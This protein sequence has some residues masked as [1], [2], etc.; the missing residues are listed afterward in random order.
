MGILKVIA[1]YIVLYLI[2]TI[3]VKRKTKWKE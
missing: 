2:A 3:E 1:F